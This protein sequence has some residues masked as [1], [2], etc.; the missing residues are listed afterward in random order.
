MP[1]GADAASVSH[2]ETSAIVYTSAQKLFEHVDDHARLSAHMSQP[3]WKLGGG[4]MTVETDA[5]GGRKVGSR[6]R[7]DGRVFGIRLFLE[8]VV[9]ERD[10]PRRK[11]WETVGEPRLLVIGRYRRGFDIEPRGDNAWFRVFI[12]Y[13]L[14]LSRFGNRM[15]RLFA[16]YYARWCIERMA[17]DAVQAFA[18]QSE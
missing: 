18:R 1:N 2:H 13:T 16:R 8:E 14:P 6:I 7:V 12:D 11:V 9:T 10:P 5:G 17:N 15:G 4:C 3:S